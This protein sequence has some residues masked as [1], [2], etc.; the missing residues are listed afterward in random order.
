LISDATTSEFVPSREARKRE[1]ARPKGLIRGRNRRRRDSDCSTSRKR[2]E[3]RLSQRLPVVC[4]CSSSQGCEGEIRAHDWQQQKQQ[5]REQRQEQQRLDAAADA[6]EKRECFFF[7]LF[8]F[9]RPV[10]DDQAHR[11]EKKREKKKIESF[12][13]SSPSLSLPPN[14]CP[15]N[16]SLSSS[17]A[18]GPASQGP[19]RSLS[20]NTR[21][22]LSSLVPGGG[23]VTTYE[24]RHVAFSDL[25][26]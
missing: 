2:Q 23:L 26:R 24:R 1:E 17:S 10:F 13:I 3:E 25:R 8:T 22:P 7:F 9:F 15:P 18:L 6:R 16:P 12:Y 14:P 20:T 5:Q 19:P 11:I 21:S 4:L